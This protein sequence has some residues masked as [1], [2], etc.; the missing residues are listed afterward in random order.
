MSLDHLL[1][2]IP[3]RAGRALRVPE[4]ASFKVINTHG[5]Q[6]V[7]TWAFA[8]GNTAEF[9]SME[10]SRA[11]MGT[12]FP[13]VGSTLLSNHRRP[14]LTFTED[15]SGGRH[16]TLIAACDPYRYQLLGCTEPHAN[17]TENLHAALR[18]L[19]L[20]AP[21]TPCPLNLFMNIPLDA[22]GSV[23]FEPPVCGPGAWVTLRAERDLVVVFSACPQDLVPVNGVN[24]TPT[25]AHVAL[26]AG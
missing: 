9:M 22:T 16:D 26:I 10:H 19:A 24:C 1:I 21:L 14:M 25:E 4:G 18:E 7:D 11:Q 13:T 20:V 17:C 8:D 5:Q 23:S 15:T 3:A 2:T 12:V 6:V